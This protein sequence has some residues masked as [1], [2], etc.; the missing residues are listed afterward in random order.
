MVKLKN[1]QW[2]LANHPV[3]MIKE[4][5]FNW[6]KEEVEYELQEGELLVKNYY[7]SLDPANRS[8]ISASPKSH[9]IEPVKIGDVMRG[10]TIGQVIESKNPKYDKGEYV[11]GTLGWQDYSVS[12]GSGLIN[13]SLLPKPEGVSIT[14]YLNVLGMIGL[15][16]YFG[17]LEIGKPKV[18]ETL[19]VSAAAGAVGSLVGQIGKIKGCRVIGI[20]G[21]EEKCKWLTEELKFDGAINYKTESVYKRLKELCPNGI[22]IYYEN[23]GGKILD[24]ALANLA[25]YAR[26]PVCGMISKYNLTELQPGPSN[27]VQIVTKRALMQGFI[28]NDFL[29]RIS[30]A[31][32][33]LMTWFNEGKLKY[34]EHIIQGLKNAPRAINM[35]FDGSNK[36]KLII[37]I[38]KEPT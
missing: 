27:I 34:R 32:L 31:M 16:A 4:S 38:A 36:G 35:L 28:V 8:W 5:D 18:G 11:I 12:K 10:I 17:L 22:D 33:D 7:L 21:T 13:I 24:A 19:V 1:R 14:I 9:Y 6:V 37:Q 2:R 15:T 25:V 26:I 30:E 23:V 29:G 3:G 20:A